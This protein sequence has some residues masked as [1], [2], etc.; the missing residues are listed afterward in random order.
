MEETQNWEL[1]VK[2]KQNHYTF[3]A[4]CVSTFQWLALKS[5][6]SDI[7]TRF[8]RFL[9]KL[10]AAEDGHVSDMWPKTAICKKQLKACRSFQWLKWLFGL[11]LHPPTH[12]T[13]TRAL[14]TLKLNWDKSLNTRSRLVFK[15]YHIYQRAVIKNKDI[16]HTFI[17]K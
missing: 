12:Q 13:K 3:T 1:G 15:L 5:K 11:S 7:L 9:F 10:E 14:Y 6:N 2:F 16:L 17:R 4:T 8:T